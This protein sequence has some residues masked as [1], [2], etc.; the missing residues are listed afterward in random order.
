V[1]VIAVMTERVVLRV[2]YS[3]KDEV[4][5]LGAR[6]DVAQRHWYVPDGVSLQAFARWLPVQGSLLTDSNTPNLPQ[7]PSSKGMLLTQLMQRVASVVQ[8]S[9]AQAVWV[10]AE[11]TELQQRQ[12]HWYLTLAES[13]DGQQIAQVKA[14]LW[15]TRASAIQASFV[16]ATGSWLIT[17]QRVLLL[18]DVSLHP[19]F[20]FSLVVQDIDPSY[21]LGEQARKLQMIRRTLQA[22]GLYDRNRQHALPTTWL[23][24]AVLSPA[25]AA[26]LGDF[27]RDADLLVKHGLCQFVYF[28]AS[29]QGIQVIP[30]MRFALAQIVAAHQQRAFDALVIIRGGGAQQDLMFLNELSIAQLVAQLP[31]PVI[32]GI[33]HERDSTILDEIAHLACD[34]PSKVIALIR[35]QIVQQAKAGAGAWQRIQHQ[36]DRQL[37]QHQQQVQQ[38]K[39]AVLWAAQRQVQQQQHRLSSHQ[40]RIKDMAQRQ[41]HQHRQPLVTHVRRI[42]ELAQRQVSLHRTQVDHHAQLVRLNDPRRLLAQGYVLVTSVSDNGLITSLE[43]ARAA[44]DLKLTFSDASLVISLSRCMSVG[45]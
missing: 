33:G 16:E 13:Q 14:T 11:I 7:K 31:L 34:T 41:V 32:T 1:T 18:C 27:R 40:Q 17:G 8:A 22:E 15:A 35:D 10:A 43:Q 44:G 6:W 4:K 30:E 42:Q 23:R 9:F 29:F 25:Q 21:T 20:G 12:G 36:I 38:H 24:V 37:Q 28:H 3:E 39:Q 19:R 45:A 26:G 5:R 2:A